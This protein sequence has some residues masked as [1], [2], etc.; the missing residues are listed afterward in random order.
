V[1]YRYTSQFLFLYY[2]GQ[3]AFLETLPVLLPQ[4]QVNHPLWRAFSLCKHDVQL[5]KKLRI[6]LKMYYSSGRQ[7]A[8]QMQNDNPDLVEQLRQQF[9]DDNGK[10]IVHRSCMKRIL[11]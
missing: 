7:M 11:L 2:S 9:G 1:F 6:E 8:E 4:V 10:V 3:P 5:V